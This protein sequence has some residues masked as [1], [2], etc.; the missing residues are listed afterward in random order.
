MARGLPHTLPPSNLVPAL[1]SV[2]NSSSVRA[3]MLRDRLKAQVALLMRESIQ[4]SVRVVRQGKA[5]INVRFL[6]G[7]NTPWFM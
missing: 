3:S 2:W 1:P 4:T 6:N 5:S 7:K